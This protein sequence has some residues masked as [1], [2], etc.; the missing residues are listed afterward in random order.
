MSAI[1][2]CVAQ[3]ID[4]LGLLAM[5]FRGTRDNAMRQNIAKE[6]GQ[7]VERLINS[8]CWQEMPAFEDQLP[9]DWMPQAFFDYWLRRSTP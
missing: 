8:G 1:P 5:K 4:K 6:Y 7:A 3:D 9:D 2:S